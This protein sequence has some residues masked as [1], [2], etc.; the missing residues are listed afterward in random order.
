MKLRLITIS[1]LL[2]A[3][4]AGTASADVY[5]WVDEHGEAHY[6]DRWV[7]G[8][9]LIRSSKPHPGAQGAEASHQSS[10]SEQK[11]VAAAGAQ[12]SAEAAQQAA[13]RAMKQDVAKAREQQCK[14]AQERYTQAV[15]ARRLYKSTKDGER[16]YMS[17]DEADAYRL[18]ARNEVQEACG[19]PPAAVQ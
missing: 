14:E 8:S 4:A 13:A 5:R 11:K 6:T 2:F 18:K 12:A 9:E 16:D 10:S 1:A 7:P 17:D 3:G 15:Q 19:K